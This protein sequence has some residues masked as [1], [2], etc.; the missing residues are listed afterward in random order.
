M[1]RARAALTQRA[2]HSPPPSPSR[3][4][5]AAASHPTAPLAATHWRPGDPILFAPTSLLHDNLTHHQPALAPSSSTTTAA[6]AGRA[7]KAGVPIVFA[8]HPDPQRSGVDKAQSKGNKSSA[9]IAAKA[10]TAF[11]SL[12]LRARSRSSR[13]RP[14]PFFSSKSTLHDFFHP[15]PASPKSSSASAT[16]DSHSSPSYSLA[17]SSN[18]SWPALN[19][20]DPP[21][22]SLTVHSAGSTV[23]FSP[24]RSY[25][26][27]SPALSPD[28]SMAASDADGEVEFGSFGAMDE[29]GFGKVEIG[30]QAGP[31]HVARVLG[32]K[33]V[34][35]GGT[36]SQDELVALTAGVD[37]DDELSWDEDAGDVAMTFESASEYLSAKGSPTAKMSPDRS[38]SAIRYR[39]NPPSPLS[40]DGKPDLFSPSSFHPKAST[41]NRSPLAPLTSSSLFALSPVR[42][43]P[44]SSRLFSTSSTLSALPA[45]K[46]SPSFSA[47]PTADDD[48]SPDTLAAGSGMTDDELA[49]FLRSDKG[50]GEP[51]ALPRDDGREQAF[52]DGAS[53]SDV[54]IV[55]K[56]RK[57][58]VL[59]AK[60]KPKAA[61]ASGWFARPATL[62][63]VAAAA[64]STSKAAAP[65][66]PF[67]VAKPAPKAKLVVGRK[68]KATRPRTA[69]QEKHWLKA[70]AKN[71]K[72][73][74]LKAAHPPFRWDKWLPKPRM[75]YT[76]EEKV[77][78]EVLAEMEG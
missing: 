8:Q 62:A 17:S 55:V 70:T 32:G 57:K 21:S 24:S 54:E 65:K 37:F 11:V 63:P 78:D 44:S 34:F 22:P 29:W 33:S 7:W 42:P 1:Q 9:N 40:S 25:A 59:A 47:N 41:S 45:R 14:L 4:R 51:V 52:W 69:L 50:Q 56:P 67:V 48:A 76:I 19:R 20:W 35:G 10:T 16:V 18:D 31:P 68:D 2:S 46:P 6:A 77:V 30:V 28:A 23:R 73:A 64:P 38:S 27:V 43:V 15:L 36:L 71:E 5:Q 58:P 53:D 72:D 13:S 61:A 74:K 26:Q 75:V 39:P 66:A 60:P 12:S 3:L 49:H